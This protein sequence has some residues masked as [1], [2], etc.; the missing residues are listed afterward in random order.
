MQEFRIRQG[1]EEDI[2]LQL[3]EWVWQ[4]QQ[5]AASLYAQVNMSPR[6]WLTASSR[7]SSGASRVPV[8]C[9]AS[10]QP[11]QA[12]WPPSAV[13]TS[14]AALQKSPLV[15]TL[16]SRSSSGTTLVG[17]AR[18]TTHGHF[19]A[20]IAELAMLPAYQ[21][22]SIG[23]L[24]LAGVRALSMAM[25]C[26]PP[27]GRGLAQLL[28]KHI[29]NCLLQNGIENCIVFSDAD[30]EPGGQGRLLLSAPHVPCLLTRWPAAV[31]F[32]KSVGFDF[33]KGASWDVLCFATRCAS[34]ASEAAV[35]A[36]GIKYAAAMMTCFS[37][38][39]VGH[40]LIVVLCRAMLYTG[41]R[42]G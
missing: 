37:A 14:L 4:D 30:G 6:A 5:A 26:T 29:V 41:K 11:V 10:H 18:T 17:M 35:R 39:S 28:I 32:Y 22:G 25:T 9:T 42:R 16:L 21:V 13:S 7:L 20:T 36:D 3:G 38:G 27:Q 1:E 19:D 24:Q 15:G 40:R 31:P 8:V 33:T 2:W 23:Q 12:G 34:P